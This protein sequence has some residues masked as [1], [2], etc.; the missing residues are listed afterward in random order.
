MKHLYFTASVPCAPF[1]PDGEEKNQA[2][3]KFKEKLET[4]IKNIEK[5]L[6]DNGGDWMVGN[7][8]TWADLYVAY[9]LNQVSWN[10]IDF[11]I[12]LERDL[13]KLFLKNAVYW[14][15]CWS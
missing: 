10:E 7:E 15:L 1:S 9:V 3:E 8:F 14:G 11:R 5:I 12:E 13:I 2:L 6:E 4:F